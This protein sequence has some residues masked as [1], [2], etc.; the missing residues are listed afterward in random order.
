MA[1][2]A[3]FATLQQRLSPVSMAAG[4]GGQDQGRLRASRRRWWPGACTRRGDDEC[5]GWRPYRGRWG[6]TR[7][8]GQM[9]P[10]EV[11][12]ELSVVSVSRWGNEEESG[13]WKGAAQA[14]RPVVGCGLGKGVPPP[15]PLP[16]VVMPPPEGRWRRG[17]RRMRM[18]W[19]Q[20]NLLL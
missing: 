2:E 17:E 3:M 16:L 5:G 9:Q 19:A 11:E 15:V 6:P 20:T 18:R 13:G 14:G 7:R 1:C 8:R 4:G 10:A 12:G